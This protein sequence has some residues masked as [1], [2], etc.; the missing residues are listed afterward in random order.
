VVI[1]GTLVLIRF[2]DDPYDPGLGALKPV[3]MERTLE[4]LDGYRRLLGDSAPLPCGEQGRG[5]T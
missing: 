2:L 1:V 4:V 3:A 5:R